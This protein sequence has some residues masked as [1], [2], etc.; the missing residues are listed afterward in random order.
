MVFI[1][2]FKPAHGVI[3]AHDIMMIWTCMEQ[4][5]GAPIDHGLRALFFVYIL[6]LLQNHIGNNYPPCSAAVFCGSVYYFLC[7][8]GQ[9][10]IRCGGVAL[11]DV[12]DVRGIF[13]N[14]CFVHL[15]DLQTVI[16]KQFPCVHIISVPFFA[17]HIKNIISGSSH[18]FFL[19][20][21][22]VAYIVKSP[23]ATGQALL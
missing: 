8:L 7:G 18:R 6:S 13:V 12:K 11:N 17:R 20:L 22:T 14:S 21:Y 16:I 3:V 10:L 23:Q 4:I 1:W 19:S 9:K 2:T 15:P 5:I